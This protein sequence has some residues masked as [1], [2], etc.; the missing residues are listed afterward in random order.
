[1]DDILQY[2]AVSGAEEEAEKVFHAELPAKPNQD[3]EIQ[4]IRES[5]AQK[6]RARQDD[7]LQKLVRQANTVHDSSYVVHEFT[8]LS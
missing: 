7:F 6:K 3:Q 8:L 5:L 2:L 4:S 1:M